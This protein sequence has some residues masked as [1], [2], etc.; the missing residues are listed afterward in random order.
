[1]GYVGG[2]LCWLVWMGKGLPWP[3]PKTPGNKTFRLLFAMF[4]T[5]FSSEIL[6]EMK[7]ELELG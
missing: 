1:M 6:K 3:F 2:L 7:G 4:K 5:L